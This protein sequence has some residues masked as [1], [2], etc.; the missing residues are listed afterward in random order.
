METKKTLLN[1]YIILGK[2]VEISNIEN[3]KAKLKL[4]F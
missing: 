1:I 4:G 2:K 3:I